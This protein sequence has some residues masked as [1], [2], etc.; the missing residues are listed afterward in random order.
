MWFE[1]GSG[2][3]LLG[4]IGSV[5]MLRRAPH[6]WIGCAWVFTVAALY[7]TCLT[8][9]VQDALIFTLPMLLPWALWVAY[10]ATTLADAA[11]MLANR[12]AW[13]TVRRL[14]PQIALCGLL[15]FTMQWGRSRLPYGNKADQWLFRSFGEGALDRMAPGAAVISRWEQGTILQYLHLVE[16]RRPDVWVDVVEPEDW[17]WGVRARLRYPQRPVYIIGGPADGTHF[18]ATLVWKTDYATLFRIDS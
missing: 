11:A 13:P 18:G 9:A 15:A 3:L 12:V 1:W 16:G 6:T 17:P 14:L 4:A 2:G 7:F 10:G 8:R 5:A